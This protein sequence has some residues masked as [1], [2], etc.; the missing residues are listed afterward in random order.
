MPTN[1]LSQFSLTGP[2]PGFGHHGL[3]VVGISHH[4]DP[5]TIVLAIHYLTLFRNSRTLGLSGRIQT[6]SFLAAVA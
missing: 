4:W 5:S 2:G 3:C 1:R 6:H